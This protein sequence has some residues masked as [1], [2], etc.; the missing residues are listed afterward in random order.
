MEA[1]TGEILIMARQSGSALTGLAK[2]AE[3]RR[4]MDAREVQLRQEAAVEIG[5][6]LL[7]VGAEKIDLK[8]LEK[9]V[10]KVGELGASEAMKRLDAKA[11]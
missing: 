8:L 2:L 11:A 10:K 4:D 9:V 3:E 6:A 1:P 7:G 5:T